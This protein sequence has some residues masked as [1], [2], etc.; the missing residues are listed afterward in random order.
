MLG[1]TVGLFVSPDFVGLDVT[2]TCVGI[3]D[4]R[5]LGE[6]LGYTLGNTLGASDGRTLGD[7]LGDV[8]GALDG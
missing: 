2:G 4:G 3:P 5:L 6:L 1:P 7:T 8:L